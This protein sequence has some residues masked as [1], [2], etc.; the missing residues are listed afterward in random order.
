MIHT[1]WTFHLATFLVNGVLV[2]RGKNM[3]WLHSLWGQHEWSSCHKLECEQ[4]KIVTLEVTGLI[5]STAMEK[6]HHSRAQ[7]GKKENNVTYWSQGPALAVESSFTGTTWPSLSRSRTVKTTVT[8]AALQGSRQPLLVIVCTL[9]TGFRIR[10][11]FD[12]VKPLQNET[13]LIQHLRLFY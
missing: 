10:A 12:A 11:A 9:W 8:G 4:Y 2:L 13:S 1:H 6:N 3:T 7:L 5:K